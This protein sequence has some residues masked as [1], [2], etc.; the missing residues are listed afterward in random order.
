[1]DTVG[2]VIAYSSEC[3]VKSSTATFPWQAGALTNQGGVWL[4][5]L[6]LEDSYLDVCEVHMFM[7]S[8]F[9]SSSLLSVQTNGVHNAVHEL[10]HS[11]GKAEYQ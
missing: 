8:N 7:M 5:S 10:G 1:M 4:N 9:I 11:M 6:I 2:V 3:A